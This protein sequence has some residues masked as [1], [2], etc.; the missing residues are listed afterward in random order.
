MKV[1]VTG[2][3]G[4]LGAWLVE[5]LSQRGYDVVLA[6]RNIEKAAFLVSNNV[7]CI[8]ADVQNKEEIFKAMNGCEGVFHLAS[9]AA[10]WAKNPT[11]FYDVNVA[12]TANVLEAAKF[13]NVKRVLLTSSAGNFGPDRGTITDENTVRMDPFFSEYEKT[14]AQADEVA[15]EWVKKGL[16]VVIAYPTR[17]IGPVKHGQAAAVTMLV[18]RIV[19]KNFR[20]VP[21]SGS[22]L[23]NYVYI[24]DAVMGLIAAF[25]KGRT[26]EKYLLGGDNITLND[27][28]LWTQKACNR[29]SKLIH[30]P[31]PIIKVIVACFEFLSRFGIP[32]VMTQGWL[33]KIDRDYRIRMDKAIHE[34][35]YT[36]IPAQQTIE[37]TV[38]WVMSRKNNP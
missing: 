30:V 9:L 21:G 8:Q 26:G 20:L 28:Y 3:T 17:V 33:K 36:F 38:A 22:C 24:Q 23:G 13:H 25:E 15:L 6:V 12:G 18:E 1:L 11:D 7:T 34:L 29:T 2:S 5:A 10:V 32:P 4:H 16:D 31:L 35:G 14:K 27:L 19:E 37:K